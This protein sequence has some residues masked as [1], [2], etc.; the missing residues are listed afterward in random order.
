MQVEGAT[1]V[2]TPILAPGGVAIDDV[3]SVLIDRE[4]WALILN[5]AP[6]KVA[7]RCRGVTSPGSHRRSLRP[8]QVLNWLT[9]V[10]TTGASDG[11]HLSYEA[12]V[13][14]PVTPDE[15]GGG[16]GSVGGIYNAALAL[17]SITAD[18]SAFVQWGSS[19]VIPNPGVT[20]DV[21]MMLT[22]WAG[23]SVQR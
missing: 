12:G 19:L 13:W 8:L 16:G 10:D 23:G 21:A 15:G 1:L 7:E 11:Q 14:V 9:D 6:L 18:D 20:V 5:P 17:R 22:G 2:S 3:V 4:G